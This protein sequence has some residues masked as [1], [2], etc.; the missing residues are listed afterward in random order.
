MSKTAARSSGSAR[1]GF[2]PT[3]LT[4]VGRRPLPLSTPD[5]AAHAAALRLETRDGA[6][7]SLRPRA[8]A[9][10]CTRRVPGPPSEAGSGLGSSPSACPPR[11]SKA[12]DGVGVLL[13][14]ARLAKSW[15]LRSPLHP[16]AHGSHDDITGL[17]PSWNDLLLLARSLA[18]SLSRSLSLSLRRVRHTWVWIGNLSCKI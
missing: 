9:P 11:A 5:H 8:L 10:P 1:P 7:R 2:V 14:R 4:S 17:L 16:A 18:R 13:L 3:C 12:P 15:F 6:G